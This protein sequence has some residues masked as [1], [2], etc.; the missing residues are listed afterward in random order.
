MRPLQ[1]SIPFA[2]TIPSL[3]LASEFSDFRMDAKCPFHV[4]LATPDLR[5]TRSSAIRSRRLT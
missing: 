2:L 3:A 4:A 5:Q 1:L